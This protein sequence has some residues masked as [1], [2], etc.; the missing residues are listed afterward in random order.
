MPICSLVL[1]STISFQSMQRPQTS[2]LRSLHRRLHWR[3]VLF[4]FAS[5]TRREFHTFFTVFQT[6]SFMQ[7]RFWFF[8]TNKR[9][10]ASFSINVA[11]LFLS[12]KRATTAPKKMIDSQHRRK[13]PIAFHSLLQFTLTTTQLNLSFLK[14]LNY[15][16][17][18]QKLVLS[19]RN[20]H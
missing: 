9:Q 5:I 2:T 8:P 6:S 19:F 3:I 11:T 18:I 13:I 20:L 14:T 7:W 1:W 15:F 16:K 17:T 4:I 10:C 12:F